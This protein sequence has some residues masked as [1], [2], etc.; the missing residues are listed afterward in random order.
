MAWV[1]HHCENK[2]EI[3]HL[4]LLDTQE[5]QIQEYSCQL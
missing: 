4:E 5:I 1:Y 2:L 3:H